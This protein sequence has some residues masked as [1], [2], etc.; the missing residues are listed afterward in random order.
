M[1]LRE[2]ILAKNDQPIVDMFIP[3]W[4]VT[5][6]VKLW[7]A[8]QYEQYERYI[9]RQKEFCPEIDTVR[10]AAAAKS[11]V[12]EQGNRVFSDEDIPALA[13]KSGLALKR[14]FNRV[15]IGEEQEQQLE[16]GLKKEQAAGSPSS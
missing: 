14:I 16:A 13:E 8:K 12:D 6:K 9:E 5:I 2:E 7:S 10:A 3:E 11:I 4:N 15:M 1:S